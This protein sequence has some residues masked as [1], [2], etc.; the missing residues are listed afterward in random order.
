MVIDGTPWTTAFIS[1]VQFS[2]GMFSV[3]GQPRFQVHCVS[4]TSCTR[5]IVEWESREQSHCNGE[6]RRVVPAAVGSNLL[7][8]LM[9]FVVLSQNLLDNA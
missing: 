7:Q 6:I 4:A 3:S 2:R 1:L 5:V 9:F 8:T